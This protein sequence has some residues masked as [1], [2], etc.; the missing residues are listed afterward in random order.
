MAVGNLK[1]LSRVKLVVSDM[2][3]TLLN[4]EG[5]VSPE[6]FELYKELEALG[7]HFIAA[8]GRQYY[9]IIDKL[10]PIKND[11]TVIA[12]NGGIVKQGDEVLLTKSLPKKTV[13][14][15]LTK[16][17]GLDDAY[18]VLCGMKSAY[19]E[20]QNEDFIPIFSEY[21][22][23]YERVDDL[24][25]QIDQD[26]FF[27]LAVYSFDGSEQS[28]FSRF[29][30]DHKDFK[31]KVSAKNWLDIMGSDTN[32]GNALQHVQELLG[33]DSGETMVFGDYNND[34]EMMEYAAFSYA[35]ENAHPNVLAAATYT[36]KSNNA[37]GVEAILEQLISAKKDL[38]SKG[39]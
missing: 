33:I 31:A 35:M 37:L 18:I 22:K 17:R 36:T 8:S 10:A 4:D 19:I 3:G 24:A 32:K 27:K 7:I 25:A 1:D 9:S 26:D 5:I 2:D 39:R 38:A 6:F 16:L 23:K 14:E 13:R 29:D 15:L 21:Y 20:S 11:I 30:E 28:T 12:E 34:L